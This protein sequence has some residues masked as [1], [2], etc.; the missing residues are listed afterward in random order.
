[1]KGHTKYLPTQPYQR[2]TRASV[3]YGSDAQEGAEELCANVY[4]NFSTRTRP[5]AFK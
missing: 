5:A 4:F 1:M 3:Q 2:T